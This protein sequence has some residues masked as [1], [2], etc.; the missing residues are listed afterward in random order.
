[1]INNNVSFGKNL[2]SYAKARSANPL[3]FK[4]NDNCADG[5][6]IRLLLRATCDGTDKVLEEE[7]VLKAENGVEIGGMIDKDLTLYPN[8][9]YI[10]TRPLAVP[11]GVT[12]TIKPG[13]VLKF[14]AGTGFFSSKNEIAQKNETSSP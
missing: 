10:V 14:K 4:I 3:R 6:H 5:R 8:V 7:L 12:L 11:D 2:N 1:M 13:T 9:H